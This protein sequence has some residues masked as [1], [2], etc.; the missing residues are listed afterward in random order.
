ML[1]NGPDCY[2]G[3]NRVEDRQV[4]QADTIQAWW[5]G[6]EREDKFELVRDYY[7]DEAEMLDVDE[8]FSRLDQSEKVSLW[9][10]EL[11]GFHGVKI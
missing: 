6:K 8:M 1:G 2:T 9:E 7:P 10:D 5:D 3:I 4:K 11:E